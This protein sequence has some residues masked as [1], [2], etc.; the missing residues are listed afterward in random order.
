[1]SKL[2]PNQFTLPSGQ[3][4]SEIPMLFQTEMVQAIL[5]DRKTETRRTVKLDT[6][7]LRADSAERLSQTYFMFEEKALP[8]AGRNCPYG[9]PGDLLWVRESFYKHPK[10]GWNIEYKSDY[11]NTE[12]DKWQGTEWK[13]KPSIHMPKAA[14]R[15]WL[16]VESIGVERV[17]DISEQDALAEGIEKAYSENFKEWRYKD[18]FDGKRRGKLFAQFPEMAKQTGFGSMPWPD[19]R[20]PVSSYSSL[21]LSIHGE[22]SWRSN[23]WVWIIKFRVL[24]KNGRPTDEVIWQNHTE[25]SSTGTTDN[26]KPKTES[27]GKEA[28][29][30]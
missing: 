26:P 12:N 24:S 6:G 16:M 1:M 13:I 28:K 19:W 3:V 22:A 8:V 2:K 18:Y 15:I 4:I 29:N 11:Q 17:Q 25:I 21:W 27:T 30:V 14:S 9:K 7:Q 10:N 5:E 23:P 20:D